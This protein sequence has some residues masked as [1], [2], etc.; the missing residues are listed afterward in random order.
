MLDPVLVPPEI[1]HLP[2]R[3]ARVN[4][5]AETARA[6]RHVWPSRAAARD[7]WS[8]RGPFEHWTARALAL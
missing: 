2:E 7:S 8:G 4:A 6:R 3:L 5:M 1:A